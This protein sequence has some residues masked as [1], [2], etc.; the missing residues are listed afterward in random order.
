MLLKITPVIL[1]LALLAMPVRAADVAVTPKQPLHAAAPVV[2]A[3]LS[4]QEQWLALPLQQRTQIVA[5]WQALPETTRPAFP[6]YREQR[7]QP[8]AIKP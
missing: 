2:P 4:P 7:L 6:L 1:S 8:N 5:D 3:P